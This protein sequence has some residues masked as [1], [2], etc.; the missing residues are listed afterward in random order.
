MLSL[1][2]TVPK[3]E[4]IWFDESIGYGSLAELEIPLEL[5]VRLKDVSTNDVT[6]TFSTLEEVRKM[7][8]GLI[9]SLRRPSVDYRD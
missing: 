9:K 2:T 7:L 3:Q 4:A 6:N 8:E 1:D 5:G